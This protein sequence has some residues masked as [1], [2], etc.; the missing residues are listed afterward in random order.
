VARSAHASPT[1]T[2]DIRGGKEQSPKVVRAIYSCT[3]QTRPVTASDLAERSP[4]ALSWPASRRDHAQVTMSRDGGRGVPSC[5][6]LHVSAFGQN[7]GTE[8][9]SRLFPE[10]ATRPSK[11]PQSERATLSNSS[12]SDGETAGSSVDGVQPEKNSAHD[13]GHGVAGSSPVSPTSTFRGTLRGASLCLPAGTG[14]LDA[15]ERLQTRLL[16]PC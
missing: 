13:W 4:D 6:L 2:C 12:S 5:R 1:Q 10:Q 16:S 8:R 11:M 3:G 9:V 14:R 7:G 15:L